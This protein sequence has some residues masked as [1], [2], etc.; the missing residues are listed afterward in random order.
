[1]KSMIAIPVG[2]VAIFISWFCLFSL[3]TIIGEQ[4]SW[5]IHNGG[6]FTALGIVYLLPLIIILG[7]ASH[8]VG[9]VII[10]MLS[11]KR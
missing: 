1:M 5:N 3:T 10:R 8:T 7:I 2:L 11:E 4:L 9:R 6:A